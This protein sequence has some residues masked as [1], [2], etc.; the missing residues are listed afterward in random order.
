MATLNL[1]PAETKLQTIVA[2]IRALAAG[3]S[4]AV[5]T[6]TISGATTV[7]DAI[8][9]SESSQVFL[10]PL[11][12]DAAA[13]LPDVSVSNVAQGNFTVSYGAGTPGFTLNA[14]ASQC[15]GQGEDVATLPTTPPGALDQL[16]VA[17]ANTPINPLDGTKVYFEIGFTDFTTTASVGLCQSYQPL[18]PTSQPPIYCEPDNGTIGVLGTTLTGGNSATTGVVGI[19]VDLAN[20]NIWFVVNQGAG[21]KWNYD[22]SADPSTNTGGLGIAAIG[23]P[24]FPFRTIQRRC[25]SLNWQAS[26]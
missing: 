10:V 17:I 11:T 15:S 22:A 13:A 6:F 7:V 24:I 18:N 5:G 16:A 23:G 26:V 12:A 2:A 3:G 8:N 1:N 9:C 20:L 21:G 19:A 25:R 14:C 4:N